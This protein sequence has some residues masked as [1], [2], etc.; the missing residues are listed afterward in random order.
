MA[1]YSSTSS[2]RI[3]QCPVIGAAVAY[4]DENDESWLRAEVIN[5]QQ[6]GILQVQCIDYGTIMEVH[7]KKLRWLPTQF[8]NHHRLCVCVNLIKVNYIKFY[9]IIL[10]PYTTF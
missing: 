6:G 4:Y 8:L 3:A 1:Y 10:N 2:D 7:Y 9:K 5:I